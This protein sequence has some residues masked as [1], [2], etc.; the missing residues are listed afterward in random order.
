MIGV[1]DASDE[2]RV[3]RTTVGGGGG[4]IWALADNRVMS[5]SPSLSPEDMVIQLR[6]RK[7]TPI[8]WNSA[9]L[10]GVQKLSQYQVTPTK[11]AT[12]T[13]TVM[14]LLAGPRK[15][16]NFS[17][18]R[19]M[20]TNTSPNKLMKRQPGSKRPK[21]E[22]T[23]T[24]SPPLELL[25]NALSRRQPVDLIHKAQH[26][27]I[28]QELELSSPELDLQ[29]VEEQLMYL[30]KKIFRSLPI[31]RLSSKTDSVGFNRACVHLKA[32]K[33][34]V[35]EYAK[36]FADS[37]RWCLLL[38]YCLVAWSHVKSTPVWDNVQHN[39]VRRHCFKYLTSGSLQ[40]LQRGSW[41]SEALLKI[42]GKFGRLVED[43]EREVE[44][45]LNHLNSCLADGRR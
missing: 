18:A 44:T 19:E 42:K 17:D 7:K 43:S 40:A 28:K 16:L 34:I 36:L 37:Q 23:P 45:I 26:P 11:D 2:V 33:K 1:G 15:R 29:R 22:G 32:F 13:R 21:S 38:E 3:T 10:D 20:A 14:G 24:G 4:R 25:A 30:K 27:E 5:P 6:G 35:V 9:S 39:V 12:P 31:S 41:N 8:N